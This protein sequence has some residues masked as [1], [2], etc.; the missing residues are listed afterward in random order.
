M[1]SISL[2]NDPNAP[3]RGFKDI[4]AGK[5][6]DLNGK[7]AATSTTVEDVKADEKR[8]E[9]EE[10]KWEMR[11]IAWEELD[12]LDE[13][14]DMQTNRPPQWKDAYDPQK[15]RE[16]AELERLMKEIARYEQEL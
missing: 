14:V 3:K 4:H 13:W 12:R 11:P 1:V 10:I 9:E 7:A 6:E 8:T 2:N 5:K 16:P 15:A